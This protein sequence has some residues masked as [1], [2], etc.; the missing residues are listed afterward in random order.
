M[1]KARWLAKIPK[2][3]PEH[4]FALENATLRSMISETLFAVSQDTAF[5]A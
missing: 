3:D 5:P 2:I 1:K 4:S